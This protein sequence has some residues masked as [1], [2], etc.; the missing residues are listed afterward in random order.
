MADESQVLDTLVGVISGALYPNGT[1]QPSAAGMPCRVYRGWPN[2]AQL[3]KDLAQ[4]ISNVSV[5]ARN[6]V[7]QVVTRYPREWETL[8]QPVHTITAT[9]SGTTCT[10]GGAISTPQNVAVRA[11]GFDPVVYA[12]QASDT[13]SG[14][15]SAI[16]ALLSAKGVACS[17]AG[18][19]LTAPGG[20]SFARIG[21]A[22]T[23]IRELRRQNKSVQV[24]L[25]CSSPANRDAV[26][27]VVD[28]AM[29]ILNFISL[30]DGSSGLVRYERTTSDDATQKE[31][32]WRRDLFYWVEYPTT[33]V[34]A[35]T[36]IIDVVD[37]FTGSQ[38]P[39]AA[40][41]VTTHS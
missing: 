40:P 26:A 17:A 13:L 3:D 19:V 5:F 25:W 37:K 39:G 1:G 30:P 15:A 10:F 12:V 35:A 27:K 22:G 6:G 20:F 41:P 14:L 16:Q 32:L 28:T 36:E 11:P 8:T 34:I 2:A 29:A 31:V 21:G 9:V 23:A 33:E 18:P 7:E 4:G 24:T 38:V